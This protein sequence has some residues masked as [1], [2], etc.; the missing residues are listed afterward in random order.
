MYFFY[1]DLISA[2]RESSLLI[3]DREKWIASITLV[4]SFMW[5]WGFVL[6]ATIYAGGLGVM[7][8]SQSLRH[9][10]PLNLLLGLVIVVSVILGLILAGTTAMVISEVFVA[11]SLVIR[12][13]DIYRSLGIPF[14]SKQ[15]T[16][17]ELVEDIRNSTTKGDEPCVTTP[18]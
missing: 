2:V 5:G 14:D 8:L 10:V 4:R 1:R 13:R 7:Y 12:A 18:N 6:T 9:D 11:C 3:P 15:V 16:R 17:R